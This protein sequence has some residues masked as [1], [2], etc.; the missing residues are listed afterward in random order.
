MP[1]PFFLSARGEAASPAALVRAVTEPQSSGTPEVPE[2]PYLDLAEK[3]VRTAGGWQDGGSGRII[4]PYVH[5]E[6]PTATARYVGA[7][8]A[9]MLQ[10][11]CHDLADSCTEALD[12]VL[13]DLGSC[14]TNHGEFLVKESL[15]AFMALE[16]KAAPERRRRWGKVFTSCDPERAYAKSRT[17]TPDAERRQNFVTFA[18]AGEAMKK[19]LRL[20]DNETFFRTYLEEQLGRFDALGMYRDPGSPMVYDITARMNLELAAFYA[21]WPLPCLEELHGKLR[22]GAMCALLYQSPSGEMP[23]GGRSNQQNFVEAS[24][25]LICEAEA[26]RFKAEGEM[27]MASVLRRAAARAVRSVTPYLTSDPIH[28]NKNRFPPETQHGRQLSYGYYGAYTLLIASQLAA[29]GLLAD[30][31][32]PFAQT[33]P[34]ESGTFLWTTTDAFHKIF[35]NVQGSHLEL[36]LCCE[37][38]HDAVGWG[39]WHVTGAP[40]ELPLSTPVPARQTFVSVVPASGSLTF[41]PGTAAEGFASD[42]PVRPGEC[43]P[44]CTAVTENS[45]EFVIDWPFPAGIVSEKIRLSPASAEIEAVNHAEKDVCYRVPLLL[46]DGESKSVVRETETGFELLYKGWSFAVSGEG[47]KKSRG[48]RVAANRNGLYAPALFTSDAGVIKLHL[49]VKKSGSGKS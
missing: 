43:R 38:D 41:G 24:F 39:R 46:T 10:G 28:F 13:D 23:F 20:A 21:E 25:A 33:T 40:P 32:I 17:N 48:N 42:L 34:A 35:A 5:R 31:T 16:K 4:D 11:R 18:L 6:T 49:S 37:G 7:L 19:H 45:V 27:L 36:E 3:I 44:T 47:T 30:R 14:A 29:A 8:G 2:A 22:S 26:R 1:H 12:A 9:L 15:F